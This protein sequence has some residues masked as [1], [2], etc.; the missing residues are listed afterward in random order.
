MNRFRLIIIFI[1]LSAIFSNCAKNPAEDFKVKK[2]KTE[3]SNRKN[4][5]SVNSGFDWANTSRF[6][7]I[8]SV[9]QRMWITT[10]EE[11]KLLFTENGGLI[12]NTIRSDNTKCITFVDDN[13]GWLIDS[14]DKLWITKDGG[15]NW[16]NIKTDIVLSAISKM[17]FNDLSNGWIMDAFNL[18]Y[19]QDGGNYW[20]T[21]LSYKDKYLKG[22]PGDFF[23]ISKIL[24]WVCNEGDISG[25]I[26]KTSDGGIVW[27][28]T[29][30]VDNAKSSCEIFFISSQ[31]GWY[32]F[33]PNQMFFTSDG[34]K[35]WS[36][37][38]TIPDKFEARSIFWF[39]KN[40]GW[41]AGY[42]HNVNSNAPK[43]G[44]GAV[45]RTIDGG[46][47]WTEIEIERDIPFF[48]K[49]Y[50]SD[51]QNGWL[52]SRDSIYIT[53]DGGLS[54]NKSFSLSPPAN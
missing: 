39:N 14:S 29:R 26:L 13:T 18:Y 17:E 54:W 11:Q 48:D 47:N 36:K 23:F 10:A 34:G 44:K 50:F 12:W 15:R 28:S 5:L 4:L 7:C 8:S 45:L 35:T 37:I 25:E 19:T 51:S 43:L 16:S 1:L 20:K 30:I 27:S 49:V 9:K 53:S 42:F 3:N 41:I 6:K 31:E 2:E 32:S 33:G 46:Q 52:V 40:E 21:I 22:Q 24:G 38:L